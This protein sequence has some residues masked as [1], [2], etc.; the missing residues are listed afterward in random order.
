MWLNNQKPPFNDKSLRQA[1]S[2][3]VDRDTINQ[4]IFFGIGSPGVYMTRPNSWSFDQSALVYTHDPAKAKAALAAGGQPEG[5]KFTLLVNNVT[6]DQQ[7][8]QAI[9]GQLAP[10]GIQVDVVPL[11]SK[12][13]ADRRTSGDYEASIAQ[14]PPSADPDQEVGLFMSSTSTVNACH[15]A[16]PQ[17]DALL[18][19]GRA[20]TD[21][22]QRAA[23]YKQ[24]Q[25]ILQHDAPAVHLHY[26]ADT[27]VMRTAVQGFQPAFDGFV[28][29]APLW[30][31]S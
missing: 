4:A 5:F 28:R 21:T 18:A 8:G 23:V 31:Q 29:V 14:S 15:Y 27:K 26:E 1:L 16:N 13:A 25:Q 7:V 11:E 12:V 9:Q 20:V 17:I 30:L 10:L 24:I 6:T 22:D 2:W 19:Q 3:A